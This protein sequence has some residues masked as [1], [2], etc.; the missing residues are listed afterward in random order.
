MMKLQTLYPEG[1]N[2][3]TQNWTE[4]YFIDSFSLKHLYLY[5]LH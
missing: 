3:S 2:Q 5:D 4:K 1:L